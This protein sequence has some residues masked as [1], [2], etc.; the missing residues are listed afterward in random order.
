MDE[1]FNQPET[2]N[3]SLNSILKNVEPGLFVAIFESEELN[4]DYW[5]YRPTQWFMVSN[6]ATQIFSGHDYTDIFINQFDTLPVQLVMQ[7]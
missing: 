7:M 3:L 6:I 5:D 1:K 2:I 4:L